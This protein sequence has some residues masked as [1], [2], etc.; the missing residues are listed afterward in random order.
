MKKAHGILLGLFCIS[1]IA[2]GFVGMS[3][4]QAQAGDGRCV[5]VEDFWVCEDWPNCSPF[6][7]GRW[8]EYS[9]RISGSGDPCDPIQLSLFCCDPE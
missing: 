4:E 3:T 9:G 8:V 6:L 2:G 1:L 7:D 5:D